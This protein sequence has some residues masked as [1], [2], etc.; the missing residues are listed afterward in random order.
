[1][2]FVCVFVVV[3][4]RHSLSW[5]MVTHFHTRVP[6]DVNVFFM[7]TQSTNWLRCCSVKM[8]DVKDIILVLRGG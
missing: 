7:A 3:R 6:A 1:M 8:N 4:A 5:E 2:C